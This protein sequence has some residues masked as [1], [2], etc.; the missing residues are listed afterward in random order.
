MSKGLVKGVISGDTII[1]SKAFSKDYSL[2]EEFN[3]TL[4]GVIAPKIGNS[5]KLEEEPYSFES[6]EFL[7]K[8]IIGKVVNYKIDFTK[9]N[10]TKY[11]KNL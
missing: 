2:P 10:T 4:T 1:I 7:R 9:E 11:R 3:L 5:S 6:R 8:L